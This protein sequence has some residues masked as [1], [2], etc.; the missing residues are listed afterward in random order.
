MIDFRP[1]TLEDKP[2]YESYLFDGSERGCNYSFAN[3]FLWGEQQMAIVHDHLA[4]YSRYSGKCV[5]PFPL[6]KGD[7]KPVL[8]AILADAKERGVCGCMFGLRAEDQEAVEAIYPGRFRFEN[9]PD[10]ADYVY[11]IDDLADLK[12]RK[13]HK[14]RNHFYH[15]QTAYPNY[16]VVPLEESLLPR[17]REMLEDWYRQR[18]LEQPDG[19]YE[20]EQHAL[21]K[22]LQHYRALEMDGMV[23]L[24]GEDVLAFTMGSRLSPD[25]MDIHFEKAHWDVDGAYTAINCEFARYIRDRYPDIRF[26]NREEDM[27]LEGL[28]KSKQSYQPHHMAEKR[29]AL[30]VEVNNAC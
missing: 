20:M 10:V 21:F 17:V 28:R 30:P 12:G 9:D 13:Y 15:F 2:L 26:L 16:T 3:L 8:D 19:D 14:K 29:R 11:S 5:Y 18:M 25:T 24:N 23:L 1:F 27:G 7:K 6:G 22:A 4:L